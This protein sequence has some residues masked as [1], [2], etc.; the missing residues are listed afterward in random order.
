[1]AARASGG[2]PFDLPPPSVRPRA[3]LGGLDD[4]GEDDAAD[5]EV[6]AHADGIAGDENRVGAGRVVEEPR[7]RAPRLGRQGAVDDAGAVPR[8]LQL[9]LHGVDGLAGE[10]DDAVA[11]P[12]VRKAALQRRL[13]RQRREALVVPHLEGVAAL[14]DHLADEGYGGGVAADVQLVGGQTQQRARPGEA[15]LLVRCR[16]GR[17]GWGVAERGRVGEV[18]N[19]QPAPQALRRRPAPAARCPPA[20]LRRRASCGPPCLR[21]S[22][23]PPTR[24]PRGPHPGTGSRPPRR[25][26]CGG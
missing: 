12:D 3:V 19:E 9:R 6:Q 11:G 17:A 13:H 7:L 8:L 4:G 20:P 15:A 26:R 14:G 1:M 23:P 2:R 10:G 22:L 5:V 21:P 25:R 24:P 16:G 18:R